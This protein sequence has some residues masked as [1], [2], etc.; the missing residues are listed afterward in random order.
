MSAMRF[1]IGPDLGDAPAS[2][3]K[4]RKQVG[5]LAIVVGAHAV[6][7]Y[8]ISSGMLTRVVDAALPEAVLISFVASPPAP[9]PPAPA[10]P[11]TVMLAQLPPPMLVP[12]PEVQIMRAPEPLPDADPNAAAPVFTP[13]IVAAPTPAPPSTLPKTITSGVEYIQA[14]RPVYPRMSKRMGEQGKVVL[15]ILVNEKGLPDHVLVHTS[16]GSSRLDEAGRQAAL[17]ALFKPHMEGGRAVAVYVIVPL[18]FQLAG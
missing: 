18:N 1:S 16:S 12:L 4:L 6:L 7:F 13:V 10:I 9:P 17:R 3:A 2:M 5:P 8:L 14:P 15:R 11:K